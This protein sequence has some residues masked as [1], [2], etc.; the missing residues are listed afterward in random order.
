MSEEPKCSEKILPRYP[1]LFILRHGETEWNLA[2]RMQG[3][4]DSALTEL[5]REQARRQGRLLSQVVTEACEWFSS[6]QGRAF[7]TA[8]IAAP[9]GQHIEQDMRLKEIG[10]GDWTGL[11]RL[12]IGQER[13]DLFEEGVAALSYYGQ[14]P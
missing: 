5:G 4:L 11:T 13:P 12:E 2:G 8:R 14:G 1:D 6:P 10:M 3:H 9:H 7:N